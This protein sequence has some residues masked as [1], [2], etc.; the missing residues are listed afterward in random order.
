MLDVEE[1]AAREAE[2]AAHCRAARYHQA[3]TRALECFGPEIFGY[4]VAVSRSEDEAGEAFAMFSED[5]WRG[6]AGFRWQASLRT[7]AYQLARNA[8]ARLRRDTRRHAGR[9]VA[10]S[11]AP[12]VLGMADRVRTAT[13]E[14]LRTEVKDQIAELRQQLDPDD[15]TLL[16]LRIGRNMSWRDIAR[17]L[18]DEDEPDPEA[19]TRAAARLRKRFERVKQ[20]LA[21]LARERGIVRRGEG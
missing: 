16:I 8:L 1:R 10:L 21:A 12:E 18:G 2:I 20:E 15:Q 5:L 7:W 17:V 13:L 14:Y 11:R 3:T 19:L 4:L 9:E 6:I